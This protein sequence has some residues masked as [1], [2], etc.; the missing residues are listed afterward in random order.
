MTEPHAPLPPSLSRRSPS[1]SDDNGTQS[2]RRELMSQISI[3]ELPLEDTSQPR[4]EAAAAAATAAS[5][6]G[7]PKELPA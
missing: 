1:C 6:E 3:R 7:P 2:P 5:G 4:E